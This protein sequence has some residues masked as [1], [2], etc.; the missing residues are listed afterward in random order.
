MGFILNDLQLLELSVAVESDRNQIRQAH[1][2]QI[3]IVERYW[4]SIGLVEAVATRRKERERERERETVS[5]QL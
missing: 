1:S 4:K 2:L 3:T 5:R